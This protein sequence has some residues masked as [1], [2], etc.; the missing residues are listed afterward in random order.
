MSW[1]ERKCWKNKSSE[2]ET[3]AVIFTEN[4]PKSDLSLKNIIKNIEI[5]AEDR[6]E[7]LLTDAQQRVT[8][9]THCQEAGKDI[10]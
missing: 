9:T 3:N 2:F 5:R 1:V 4:D 8:E 10:L 7:T 6:V